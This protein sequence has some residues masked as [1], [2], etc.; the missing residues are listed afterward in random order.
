MASHRGL[1]GGTSTPQRHSGHISP[2]RSPSP[3]P[4]SVPLGA[5][6]PASVDS[7]GTGSGS[8]ATATKVQRLSSGPAGLTPREAASPPTGPSGSTVSYAPNF[9]TCRLTPATGATSR[10]V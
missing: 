8:T 5:V 2:R 7:A 1:V 3:P 10:L 4:Q 6:Y 9:S